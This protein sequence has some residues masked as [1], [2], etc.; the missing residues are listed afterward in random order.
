VDDLNDQGEVD[1][2]GDPMQV[3]YG[4]IIDDGDEIIEKDR[5]EEE[6]IEQKEERIQK[7]LK[8]TKIK[9]MVKKTEKEE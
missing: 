2:F 5:R 7:E 3:K 1:E 8:M 4:V 6:T 9:K